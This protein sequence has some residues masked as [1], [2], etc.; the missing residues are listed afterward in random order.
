MIGYIFVTD[1]II[2]GV[3]GAQH[4]VTRGPGEILLVLCCLYC[5]EQ[6]NTMS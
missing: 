1:Q 4:V 6:V 2:A 5:P 3:S